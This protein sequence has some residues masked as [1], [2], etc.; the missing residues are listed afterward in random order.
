MKQALRISIVLVQTEMIGLC[1]RS[2][3]TTGRERR[4]R[5]YYKKYKKQG[6]ELLIVSD[7]P[8][9]GKW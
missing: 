5:M 7:E 2:I 1:L 4:R 3:E 6:K 8:F 9:A